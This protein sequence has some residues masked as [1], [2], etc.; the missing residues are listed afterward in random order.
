MFVVKYIGCFNIT[1]LGHY[2]SKH[3]CRLC[4]IYGN[5]TPLEYLIDKA[6]EMHQDKYDYSLIKEITNNKVKIEVICNECNNTFNTRVDMHINQGHGCPDCK[7][8]QI[9][10]KQYY[11][12][13]DI[14][15]HPI[16]LYLVQF[17][18]EDE[19]FLKVGLIIHE[20]IKKR[21][22][23]YR[24]KYNIS[25]IYKTQLM[26]F[27]AYDIEQ[28]ILKKFSNFKHEPLIKFKGHTECL[29]IN[30][31]EL[32]LSTLLEIVK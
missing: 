21:F 27:K 14:P 26:F 3:G 23:G 2:Y 7:K 24:L 19:K 15:E 8:A 11:I 6:K 4:A 9:Y 13:K 31:K 29:N 10:T 1:V 20:N 5:K 32:L 28:S 16:W 22:R 25:V 18:S 30:Q 17:E 12:S